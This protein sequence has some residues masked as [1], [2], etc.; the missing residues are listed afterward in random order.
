MSESKRS[1][2][3]MTSRNDMGQGLLIAVVLWVFL[4]APAVATMSHE[5]SDILFLLSLAACLLLGWGANRVRARS[6]PPDQEPHK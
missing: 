1:L 6:S 3:V 2:Y 5:H 4:V